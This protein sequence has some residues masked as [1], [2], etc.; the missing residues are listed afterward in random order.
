[1]SGGP[2]VARRRS[3]PVAARRWSQPV[4]AHSRSQR[5][6]PSEPVASC[7]AAGRTRRPGAALHGSQENGI[8]SA[9]RLAARMAMSGAAAAG[10]TAITR[11]T[12][13]RPPKPN[14]TAFNRPPCTAGAAPSMGRRRHAKS[15]R[16]RVQWAVQHFNTHRVHQDLHVAS[17]RGRFRLGS[18]GVTTAKRRRQRTSCLWRSVSSRNVFGHHPD[19]QR[20]T[21]ERAPQPTVRALSGSSNKQPLAGTPGKVTGGAQQLRPSGR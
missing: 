17:S 12:A 13:A 20:V 2:V 16:T 9:T 8:S 14:H 10:G 7:S 3:Q 11:R 5:T 21:H 15:G 1:M 19:K 4:A 6:A 18:V